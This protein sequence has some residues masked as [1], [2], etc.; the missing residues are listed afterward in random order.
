M[1]LFRKIHTYLKMVFLYLTKRIVRREDYREEYN[2]AASTYHIWLN[3][4]NKHTNTILKIDHLKNKKNIHILDFACGTGY[5]SGYV[6][7]ELK[8]ATVKITAV[9]ISDKMI[10][11]AKDKILDSRCSL[12]VQD[13]TDFLL[14]EE[15]EKYDAIFCG[16]ALPYF[17]QKK[18]IKEFHRILKKDG[19]AH[20]ITNCKGTLKGIDEIYIDT[21]K[22]YPSSLNKIMEIRYQLPNNQNEIKSWF[23]RRQFSTIF[24]DTVEEKVSFSLPEDLYNWLKN[25]GAIAGT[26][27]IFTEDEKIVESIIDKIKNRCYY[28][29]KYWINHKFIQGIFKKE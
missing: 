4:M 11:L 1:K 14:G 29:D 15:D 22:E 3:K 17:N 13:G 24:L 25:T 2:I 26:G 20:F 27:H 9:D 12:I 7:S 28:E 5:I 16:Y 23:K 8:D 18:V 10:E 19:T 6:L 21:M